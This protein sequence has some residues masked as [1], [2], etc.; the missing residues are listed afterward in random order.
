[1]RPRHA[2][3]R[4]FAVNNG[5]EVWV[6]PGDSRAWRCRRASSS[7]TL[8]GRRLEGHLDRRRRR[9]HRGDRVVQTAGGLAGLVADQAS[10]TEAI[11][12]IYD[13][14]ASRRTRRRIARGQHA[15]RSSSN[16][17]AMRRR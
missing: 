12:I 6:L 11:P 14:Q 7:S 15:S 16:R 8:A 13:A 9:P 4:P 3:L 10:V 2:D 5:D 17:D 1:M